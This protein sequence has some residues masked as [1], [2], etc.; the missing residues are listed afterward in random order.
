MRLSV[1]KK[2]VFYG[3]I[4]TKKTDKNNI[5][6]VTAFD[7]L[8]YFKNKDT[9]VYE[10]KTASELLKMLASDFNLQIGSVADTGYKIP[11]RVE[12]NKSL[13]DMIQSALDLTLQN[14]K[15]MYVLFDSCGKLTL[16]SMAD[17]IVGL[18][19]D[20]ETAENYDYTSS[21]DSATYNQIKLMYDNEET[22]ERDIYEVKSSENINKWGVLQFFEKLQKGENGKAK[23][24][25]LLSLYNSKTRTLS[26]NNALGDVRVRAGTMLVVALSLSDVKL[27]NLMLVEKCKH[28]FKN[29]EHLMNLTLRGGGFIA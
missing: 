22:G 17:M 28:T 20:E 21:I 18:V 11:S 3:F 19:I 4:F 24:E 12:D 29:D 16:K 10:D 8:R 9:Y 13:F 5:I 23:A 26:I 1:N 6:S 14:A 15:E 27:G 7:Q 25:A 2:G